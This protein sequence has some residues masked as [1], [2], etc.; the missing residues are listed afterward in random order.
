MLA[1]QTQQELR[2]QFLFNAKQAK[3]KQPTLQQHLL[4][5]EQEL[6]E[7]VSLVGQVQG[8]LNLVAA[9]APMFDLKFLDEEGVMD[10]TRI[11]QN[12][13]LTIGKQILTDYHS[14][15]TR[16]DQIVSQVHNLHQS[17][18]GARNSTDPEALTDLIGEATIIHSEYSDWSM[19][20]GN[21]V[22]N[23]MRDVAGHLNPL[24]PENKQIVVPAFGE[25]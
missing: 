18:A 17:F 24:R 13:L 1:P 7:L 12:Y 10:I 16:A 2:D 22:I 14:Y 11:D 5:A 8:S 21:L 4:A 9:F 19:G 3:L 6:N 20:F 23:A 25:M 15:K